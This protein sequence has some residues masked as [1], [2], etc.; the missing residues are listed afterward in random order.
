MRWFITLRTWAVLLAIALGGPAWA[1]VEDPSVPAIPPP[2]APLGSKPK[3]LDK[4]KK[5]ATS[6]GLLDKAT[7]L[8]QGLGQSGQGSGNQTNGGGK[9]TPQT[10]PAPN[11]LATTKTANEQLARSQGPKDAGRPSQFSKQAIAAVGASANARA[12]GVATGSCGCPTFIEKTITRF[13]P[14]CRERDVPITIERV[15]FRTV[16]TPEVITELV[17]VCK[18]E[19]RVQTVLTV[20][21]KEVVR[22]VECCR[23]VCVPV[24]DPCHPCAHEVRT[25]HFTR[26]IKTLVYET[27][28]VQREVTVKVQSFEKVSRTIERKQIV[29][30]VH[31]ETIVRKERY[32]VLVP[33]QVVIKVPV[34]TVAVVRCWSWHCW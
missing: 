12:V 17:P 24:C 2:L 13:R 4:D 22:E 28:P 33:Y 27:V 16:V 34:C 11:K 19:K 7:A 5:P 29:R 32:E 30:E 26:Q 14:E 10:L 31:P 18:E 20:V 1:A 9:S 21:P 8:I 25:E 6:P 15:S 3:T 23:S